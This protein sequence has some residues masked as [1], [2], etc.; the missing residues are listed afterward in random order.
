MDFFLEHI[1]D[2]HDG[3]CTMTQAALTACGELS[4]DA[5]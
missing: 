3:F 1:Y 5:V 4:R 2:T